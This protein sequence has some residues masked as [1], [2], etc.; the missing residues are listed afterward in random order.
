M[1]AFFAVVL[2]GY[3]PPSPPAPDRATMAPPPISYCFLLSVLCCTKITT[4]GRGGGVGVEPNHT[5]A[6]KLVILLLFL[7]DCIR[8]SITG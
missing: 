6:N 5:K 1:L 7:S 8:K 4:S 3:N 2:F